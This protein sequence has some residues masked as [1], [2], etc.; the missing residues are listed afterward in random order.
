MIRSEQ[1]DANARIRH[2]A[3]PIEIIPLQTADDAPAA[4]WRN[5]VSLYYLGT[6]KWENDGV[7]HLTVQDGIPHLYIMDT[8]KDHPSLIYFSGRAQGSEYTSRFH[9]GDGRWTVRCGFHLKYGHMICLPTDPEAQKYIHFVRHQ[10]PDE[11]VAQPGYEFQRV[12]DRW[13]R[14]TTRDGN[15]FEQQAVEQRLKHEGW[16]TYLD[17]RSNEIWAKR[18][19][20]QP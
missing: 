6:V 14:A 8:A 2:N 4:F 10:T 1:D 17:P 19:L 3:K 7:A 11:W 20:S 12:L 15:R 9:I 18:K 5:K 16:D 13:D